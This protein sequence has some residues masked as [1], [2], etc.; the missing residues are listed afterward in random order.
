[1]RATGGEE[2]AMLSESQIREQI[3]RV[4]AG[5][6]SLDDFEDWFAAQSW[7]MH[8]WADENLR[9][10]V[11]RVELMFAEDRGESEKDLLERLRAAVEGG[12]VV[13]DSEPPTASSAAPS[14]FFFRIPV[15][16]LGDGEQ[17]ATPSDTQNTR[18]ARTEF[19][20]SR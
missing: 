18:A 5:E 8:K 4:L 15:F 11:G 9:R 3:N 20:L 17:S 13:R 14:Q 2:S 16:R 1:M 12:V 6:L 19:A 7:D 10:L